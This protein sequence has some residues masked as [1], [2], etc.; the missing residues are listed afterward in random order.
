MEIFRAPDY[1]DAIANVMAD[2]DIM[3]KLVHPKILTGNIS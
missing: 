2:F 3:G 1:K